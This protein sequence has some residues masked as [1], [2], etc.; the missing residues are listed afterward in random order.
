MCNSLDLIASISLIVSSQ[1]TLLGV[2]VLLKQIVKTSHQ[3]SVTHI[4]QFFFFLVN[5]NVVTGW[6]LRTTSEKLPI[7]SHNK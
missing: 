6:Q 4:K 1:K 3:P 7:T 5:L 2:T